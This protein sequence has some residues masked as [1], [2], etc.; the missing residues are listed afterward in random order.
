ML[1]SLF[2]YLTKIVCQKA[3][4]LITLRVFPLPSH[5][6][7][8]GG[9]PIFTHIGKYIDSYI[10]SQKPHTQN[11]PHM[12]ATIH[13]YAV[14]FV[15]VACVESKDFF[16]MEE[17]TAHRIF[18]VIFHSCHSLPACSSS[19][20]TLKDVCRHVYGEREEEGGRK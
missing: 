1:F 6:S 12:H 15:C 9:L 18:N 20:K 4:V 19:R 5:P 10:P 2:V 14:F 11:L 3:L 16:F 13:T 8:A 17:I 7:I